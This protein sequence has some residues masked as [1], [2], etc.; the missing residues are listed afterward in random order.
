MTLRNNY[1]HHAMSRSQQRCFPPIVDELLDRFGEEKYDGY[2]HIKIVLTKKCFSNIRKE[3]GRKM[4]S[5]LKTIRV[6]INLNP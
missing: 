4:A 6:Y 3:W 5:S 2:G 1:T